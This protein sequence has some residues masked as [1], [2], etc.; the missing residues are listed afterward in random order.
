MKSI[1]V[2]M[3][4]FQFKVFIYTIQISAA[5]LMLIVQLS[6]TVCVVCTT[7]M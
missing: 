7:C 4:M 6:W 2:D 5:V 1:N 3:M